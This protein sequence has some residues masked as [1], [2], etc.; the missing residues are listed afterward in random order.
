[1]LRVKEQLLVIFDTSI[2]YDSL[3]VLTENVKGG[4]SA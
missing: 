1:M 4:C 3:T 2:S